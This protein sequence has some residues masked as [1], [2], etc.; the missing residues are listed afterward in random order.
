M[1]WKYCHSHI[2]SQKVM[3]IAINLADDLMYMDRRK[4][5][6]SNNIVANIA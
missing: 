2:V 5:T 3:G 6:R 1:T 4:G